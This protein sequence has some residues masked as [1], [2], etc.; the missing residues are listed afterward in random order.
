MVRKR[1]R[2]KNIIVRKGI[3]AKGMYIRV[4]KE[5]GLD[6]KLGRKESRGTN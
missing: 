6:R 4:R 1:L 2:F 3:W 5:V